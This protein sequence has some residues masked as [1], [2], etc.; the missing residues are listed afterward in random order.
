MHLE[1]WLTP[2]LPYKMNQVHLPRKMKA[3]SRKSW[4]P[5]YESVTLRNNWEDTVQTNLPKKFAMK[6]FTLCWMSCE[7]TLSLRSLKAR[8]SAWN[9]NYLNPAAVAV[10]I[11]LLVNPSNTQ[12]RIDIS[13]E[14]LNKFYF[15]GTTIISFF[16]RVFWNLDLKMTE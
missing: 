3:S 11:M 5:I 15:I 9:S 14:K 10:S 4:L 2:S 16:Q 7:T 13:N 1:L 8:G 6:M 12:K